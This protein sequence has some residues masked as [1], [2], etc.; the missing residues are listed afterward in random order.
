MFLFFYL[1]RGI[2]SEQRETRWHS[3]LTVIWVGLNYYG[4]GRFKTFVFRKQYAPI[5]LFY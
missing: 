5:Y 2:K 1:D 4:E 3:A